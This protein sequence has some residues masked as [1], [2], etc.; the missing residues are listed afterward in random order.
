MQRI[1]HLHY[2]ETGERGAFRLLAGAG[3]AVPFPGLN[4]QQAYL[5]HTSLSEPKD[6]FISQ[7]DSYST[8]S[9]AI[10]IIAS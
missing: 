4:K 6:V 2:S 1:H 8:T 5:R 10:K 3:N 9:T 7:D